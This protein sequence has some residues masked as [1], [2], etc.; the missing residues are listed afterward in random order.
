[1]GHADPPKDAQDQ[2]IKQQNTQQATEEVVHRI[3]TM[4]RVM[5][6]YQPDQVQQRKSLERIAGVLIGLSREQMEDVL[7]R[8]DK[9]AAEPNPDVSAKE[10]AAAHARHVEIMQ[11]LRALM[12]EYENV[13]TLDQIADKLDKLARNELELSLQSNKLI[14]DID[15]PLA[16]RGGAF[17]GFGGKKGGQGALS[18]AQLRN[19]NMK[20]LAAEQINLQKDL[21]GLLKKVADLQP[22]LPVEQKAVLDKLNSAVQDTEVN[23]TLNKTN[24]KLDEIEYSFAG[25]Q[26]ER[27]RDSNTLQRKAADDLKDLAGIVR[28]G[29]DPLAALRKAQEQLDESIKDQQ[30]LQ[31]RARQ[32]A[33]KDAK[34]PPGND[35]YLD[36]PQF[37]KG[38][39][40]GGKGNDFRNIP[41]DDDRGAKD[42]SDQQARIGLDTR[43]T[44]NLLKPF[45][46]ELADIVESAREPMKKAE[47]VLRDRTPQRA[48]EPQEKALDMLKDARAKVADMIAKAEKDRTDPLIALQKAAE[49]LEQL[50]KEQ[51]AT[52]D[53]TK[54]VGDA[55]QMDQL[56]KIA[57]QQKDLANRTDTLNNKPL[58]TKPETQMALDKAA[59]SMDKAAN[60]L[61]NQ[62][63]PEALGKQN[64]AIQALQDAQKK[65]QEQIA[66]TEKRREDIAKLEDA[67][68]KLD[69]LTKDEGKIADQ[70]KSKGD[71][72]KASTKDLGKKQGELTPQ[73]KNLAKDLDKIAQK[74]ADKV[75][76]GSQNMDAAKKELDKNQ[77]KPGADQ[78]DKAV[79]RLKEA[80]SELNKKLDDLKAKE[81]A[82]QA[83]LKNADPTAAMQQLQKAMEQTLQAM[84]EARKAMDDAMQKSLAEQ[85]KKLADQ[86]KEFN[87]DKAAEPASDAAKALNKGDLGKAL[88][89]QQQA[90]DKFQQADRQG[91]QK[92]QPATAK[93]PGEAKQGEPRSGQKQQ[94]KSDKAMGQ[95]K[96]GDKGQQGEAKAGG[97]PEP[98]EA[99]PGQPG[100]GQ[101]AKEQKEIMDATK[102]LARSQMQ[103]S[104]MAQQSNSGAMQALGQAMAGSPKG[105][106]GQMKAAAGNL[107]QAGKQ[108]GQGSPG[109][110]A[111]SQ[112]MAL[113]QM[114]QAM[115]QMLGAKDVAKAQQGQG[116][117]GQKG[118]KGDKGQPGDKQGDGQAKGE[119]KGQG[120]KQGQKQGIAQEQNNKKGDGNRTADGKVSNGQAHILDVTGT[121]TFLQLPP[122][123]REM[124]RQALASGMPPEYAAQIQQYYLNISRGK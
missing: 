93:P 12:A 2:R 106:Q 115:K 40:K 113:N 25:D 75:Q 121:D 45:A 80:Q 17:G 84:N 70:A 122:R 123:Q 97:R 3:G 48:I 57:P 34:D 27:L 101:M 95:A 10:M 85:Q 99:K 39:K 87:Y 51:I 102:Q 112:Q 91:G 92:Q 82:D 35:P 94:G 6:Y 119:P 117:Q 74:A 52:R 50:L 20:Q 28:Q 53:Q 13:S 100:A 4:L 69:K 9:A 8:L 103:Q 120:Q 78:A 38:G 29:T 88:D 23:D 61:Q 55:N 71:Q 56:P 58:P 90:L 43:D 46:K 76:Q 111:Q 98:G 47:D 77:A 36:F 26:Q 11:I 37:G 72:A 41:V 118:Q 124:I 67:A 16:S 7:R 107:G 109:Q 5:E 96:P 66:E 32:Q 68:Q 18:P 54:D 30:Q 105:A 64:D 60:N 116:K 86:A 83:A 81:L 22:K 44:S 21:D 65:L 89:A 19:Q 49:T 24:K 110:A 15:S 33:A 14:Q 59:K 31:D 1:M 63:A 108:L 104:Q 62:K 73:A 42:M 114:Q 79:A